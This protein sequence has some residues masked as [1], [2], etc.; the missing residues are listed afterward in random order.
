[1]N[2]ATSTLAHNDVV[3]GLIS[4]TKIIVSNDTGKV[5]LEYPIGNAE[6]AIL[7]A[8]ENG[9]EPQDPYKT[10]TTEPRAHNENFEEEAFEA[11][12]TRE[13]IDAEIAEQKQL[14]TE[15]TTRQT[16]ENTRS[17]I[18]HPIPAPAFYRVQHKDFLALTLQSG[19]ESS[20]AVGPPASVRISSS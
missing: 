4:E 5:N 17:N 15:I 11:T 20:F 7:K 18:V 12:G 3:L 14:E 8:F 19:S 6:A 1:M 10:T 13:D 16:E 9:G 2:K